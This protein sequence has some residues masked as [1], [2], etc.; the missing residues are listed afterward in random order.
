L[1]LRGSL[2]VLQGAG[3]LS[4]IIRQGRSCWRH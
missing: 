2:S 1:R 4:W 3:I